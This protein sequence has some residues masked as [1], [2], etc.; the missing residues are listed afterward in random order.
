MAIDLKSYCQRLGLD[1]G[2]EL[3]EGG[4]PVL[5]AEADE[6]LSSSFANVELTVGDSGNSVGSG[7]LF[8][9]TRCVQA[10]QQQ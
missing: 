8:V 1:W 3:G 6:Q 4:Q 2:L 7:T 9:T 5:D 10:Q